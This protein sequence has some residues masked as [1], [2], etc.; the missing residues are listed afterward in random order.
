M[1]SKEEVINKKKLSGKQKYDRILDIIF[2]ILQVVAI[3]I[4]YFLIKGVIKLRENLMQLNPSYQMPQITDLKI[5]IIF[6]GIIFPF[7][8]VFESFFIHIGSKI[9]L[10]KYQN[11]KTKEDEEMAKILPGKIARH[12]YK[13]FMY[14]IFVV[15]AFFI[16]RDYDYFPKYLGG[17]GQLKN[18][19]LPG[20]P[21]A[22]YIKRTKEFNYLYL[23]SLATA[24][25]DFFSL[26][27]VYGKQSDFK[28]MLLHHT[29]TVSL[30]LSSYLTNY[31]NAG[32]IVLFVHNISDLPNHITKLFL[33]IKVPKIFCNIAGILFML[34][35]IYFRIF[36]FSQ[37][38]FTIY[39]Y[40]T[41][42]WS[43]VTYS[44]EILLLFL[45][46]MNINW[47][48]IL[49]YKFIGLL[50]NIEITDNV[51][52]KLDSNKKDKKRE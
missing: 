10:D 23:S 15:A 41:W 51:E 35:F 4:I 33:K 28:N 24:I 2:A 42:K 3:V 19:Y 26:I 20:Y 12:F 48:S 14:L 46:I 45:L 13:I 18:M 50:R 5:T 40:V 8:I 34:S 31:S 49:I 47:T 44:I 52:I 43:W 37:V 29:C 30:I 25:I 27:S 38:I 1:S 17:H 11:P 36:A 7:K 9:M 32:S 22:Y 21:N 39:Y 6:L 16:L